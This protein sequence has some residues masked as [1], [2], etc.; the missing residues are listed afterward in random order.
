MNAPALLTLAG[1]T[2]FAMTFI[3]ARCSRRWGF[4]SP[5]VTACMV[6]VTAAMTSAGA[7]NRNWAV[8]AAGGALAFVVGRFGVA[9]ARARHQATAHGGETGAGRG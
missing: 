3:V 1:F 9:S 8:V 5:W 6:T 2:A 4:L 7:V